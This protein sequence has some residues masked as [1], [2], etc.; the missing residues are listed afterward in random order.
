MGSTG[1]ARVSNLEQNADL[2]R[3]ALRAA[4]CGRIFTDPGGMAREP[5]GLRSTR[6]FDHLLG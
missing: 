1:D 4:G 2:Q 6:V 3:A 5:A